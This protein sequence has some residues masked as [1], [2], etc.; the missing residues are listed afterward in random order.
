MVQCLKS[1]LFLLILVVPFPSFAEESSALT[2]TTVDAHLYPR[3]G[4]RVEIH[5][6]PRKGRETATT[7]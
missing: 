3:P 2:V 6:Y 7:R 1:V 4:H 5:R